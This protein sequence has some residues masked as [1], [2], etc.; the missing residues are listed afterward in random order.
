VMIDAG[1]RKIFERKVP[2]SANRRL[3]GDLAGGDL[4]Q[5]RFDLGRCHATCGTGSR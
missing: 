3:G 1:E 2:E 5:Q 4:R